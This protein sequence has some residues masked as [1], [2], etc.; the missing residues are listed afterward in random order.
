MVLP[1]ILSNLL[2]IFK[3]IKWVIIKI[4][5]FVFFPSWIPSPFYN[6]SP[7]SYQPLK[8]KCS[9][10]W[11]LSW[12]VKPTGEV[13]CTTRHT[14]PKIQ[15]FIFRK[16]TQALLDCHVMFTNSVHFAEPFCKVG[17]L[18][19]MWRLSKI[20]DFEAFG[21]AINEGILIPQ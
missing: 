6:L 12:N 10:S 5:L 20:I 14:S 11:C 19:F 8:S 18:V 7:P 21:E 15:L 1:I 9:L 16:H 4:Y 2:V 17:G 13:I 3:R